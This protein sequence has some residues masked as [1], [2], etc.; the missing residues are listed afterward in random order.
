MRSTRRTPRTGVDVFQGIDKVLIDVDD[1]ERAKHF[2]TEMMGCT[3]V[4]DVPYGDER[5]LE[6]RTPDGRSV[7]VLSLRQQPVRADVPDQLPTSPVFLSC[8]DIERTYRELSERG[9]V[10][11]Q[12]PIQQ[13]FGWWS[14]FEDSEG[15]R[16]ALV[17]KSQ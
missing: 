4:Q 12:P 14:M 6:V 13:P 7:L 2:W 3:V 17:P 10:F 8:N 15:N 5:W 1:Q 9:V 11:P 16:F